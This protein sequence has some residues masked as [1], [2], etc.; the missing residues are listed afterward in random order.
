MYSSPPLQGARLALEV[1]DTPELYSMWK[2]E[3]VVMSGRI[4]KMR[5]AVVQELKNAGNTQDWSH[6]VNQIGMF[7]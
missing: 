5:S 1:L 6:I 2:S 3:L 4:N 7:A